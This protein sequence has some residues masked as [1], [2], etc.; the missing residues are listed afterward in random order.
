MMKEALA[1]GVDPAAGLLRLSLPPDDPL[2]LL[3]ERACRPIR[4]LR[5]NFTPP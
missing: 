1:I 5:K 2:L 3:S 4:I